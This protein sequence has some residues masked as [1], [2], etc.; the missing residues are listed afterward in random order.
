MVSPMEKESTAPSRLHFAIE[1]RLSTKS[2]VD[3]V[4]TPVILERHEE[5]T[6]GDLNSVYLGEGD[7]A[8]DPARVLDGNRVSRGSISHGS[9]VF[10]PT[11]GN[12]GIDRQE[13]SAQS[14]TEQVLDP[15]ALQ[16]ACRARVPGPAPAPDMRRCRVYVGGYDI[17]LDF[18]AIRV[19]AGSRVV[20]GVEQ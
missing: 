10:V 2:H 13:R 18:V 4:P 6:F 5:R 8:A 9:L 20:D 14:Q 7:A 3:L 16:P 15:R 11:L 1:R 17:G 19:G 12:A